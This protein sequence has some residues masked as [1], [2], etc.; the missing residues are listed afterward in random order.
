[1]HRVFAPG[2]RTEIDYCDGIDFYC[3][4]T[5]ELISTQLFVGVLCC[6][7]LVA[8]LLD[9]ETPLR[10]LR[11]AQGVVRLGKVFDHFQ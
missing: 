8:Q 5:G 2:S 4:T 6:S 7:S 1:M 9:G 11:R 10:N 3:R